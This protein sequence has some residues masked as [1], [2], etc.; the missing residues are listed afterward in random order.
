M[1]KTH[2]EHI[3]CNLVKREVFLL[4]HLF[5]PGGEDDEKDRQQQFPCHDQGRPVLGVWDL[6]GKLHPARTRNVHDVGNML[7]SSMFL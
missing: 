5:G 3:S 2:V 7:V 1:T 6:V 4:D